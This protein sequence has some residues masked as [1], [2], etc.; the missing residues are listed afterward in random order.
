M[1][2]T[3]KLLCAL[4]LLCGSGACGPKTLLDG[5]P[6]SVRMVRSE[7]RRHP[8]PATLDGIPEGKIKWNYT[9]SYR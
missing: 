9:K 6:L 4:V 1:K 7:M 5:E 8:S 3:L 2:P